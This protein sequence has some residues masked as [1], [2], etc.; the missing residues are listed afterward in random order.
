MQPRAYR[1]PG[2]G[3]EGPS[4]DLVAA[5]LRR[6]PMALQML[7]DRWAMLIL[8][9]AFLGARRF[10][11][12]Y[13]LTG[14]PSGTL[15]ARL[16]ALVQQG[17]LYRNPL[18][19]RTNQFEYRLTGRGLNLADFALCIWAWEGK[20]GGD[21]GLPVGLRHRRCGSLTTPTTVCR[22]CGVVV[23]LE[24]VRFEP[25][26]GVASPLPGRGTS[27]LRDSSK[28]RTTQDVNLMFHRV[29]E[30]F[31]DRWSSRLLAAF[32][33]DVRRFDDL[34]AVTGISTNVLSDRLRRLTEFGILE[35]SMIGGERGYALTP[36]GLDLFPAVLAINKWSNRWAVGTDGPALVIRH[37]GCSKL[38]DNSVVCS[39]CDGALDLRELELQRS[40]GLKGS[41]P[42]IR[43]KVGRPT[44]N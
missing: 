39:R 1:R 40:K 2:Q 17:V 14:A 15:A 21:A 7:G 27:R 32:L 16:K 31:G 19:S 33:M 8:R 35:R 30:V 37:L 26:P 10:K 36:A 4:I 28:A 41:A 42:T 43:S 29:I 44:P 5:A 38:L 13:R 24:D 22:H 20:W 25:G 9:D 23:T 34:G 18:G 11:D 3:A 6:A 12:F